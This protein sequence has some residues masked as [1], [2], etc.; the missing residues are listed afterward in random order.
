MPVLSKLYLLVVGSLSVVLGIQDR[1][2][3]PMVKGIARVSHKDATHVSVC[4]A[5]TD[6]AVLYK[7][8]FKNG[9]GEIS[10]SL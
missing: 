6:D 3:E 8:N 10:I 5:L 4:K 7:Q 2:H 9:G 1:G